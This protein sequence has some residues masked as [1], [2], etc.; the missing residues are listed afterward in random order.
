MV[1]RKIEIAQDGTGHLEY[2]VN[3]S[4]VHLPS[5]GTSNHA[6]TNESGVASSGTTILSGG[7]SVL[8]CGPN[9]RAPRE[10]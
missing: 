8:S 9:P 7:S 5:V 2:H 3:L 10:T 4:D 1:Q 6:L